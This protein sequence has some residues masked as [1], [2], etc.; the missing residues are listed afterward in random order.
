MIE[1]NLKSVLEYCKFYICI[2]MNNLH[3][4]EKILILVL[5]VILSSFTVSFFRLSLEFDFINFVT[6]FVPGLLFSLFTIWL[7]WD[8]ISVKKTIIH[9]V[10]LLFC[11]LIFVIIAIHTWGIA[12]PICGTLGGVL[13]QYILPKNKRGNG[14]IFYFKGFLFGS[15]GLILFISLPSESNL[16]E[17]IGLPIIIGIW[18]LFLGFEYLTKFESEEV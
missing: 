7:Q 12:I 4:K 11:Y 14:L 9:L 8:T 13:L 5:V 18:Q 16:K 10:T 6:L 15:F 1:K 2:D 3:R 17:M